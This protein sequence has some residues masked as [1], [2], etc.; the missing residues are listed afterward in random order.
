MSET[1][2]EFIK[3]KKEA[4]HELINKIDSLNAD[5]TKKIGEVF[6]S[7]EYKKLIGEYYGIEAISLYEVSGTENTDDRRQINFLY[8]RIDGQGDLPMYWANSQDNP[9]LMDVD[10]FKVSTG[11]INSRRELQQEALQNPEKRTSAELCAKYISSSNEIDYILVHFG[12]ILAYSF[13]YHLILLD[14]N[15][16]TLADAKQAWNTLIEAHRKRKP[17][18][19]EKT[20]I[21]G[22][23]D[24]Y[25]YDHN[26]SEYKRGFLKKNKIHAI[27]E[28]FNNLVYQFKEFLAD[29]KKHSKNRELV[30]EKWANKL[31]NSFLDSSQTN[32]S[33]SERI[34]H[35]WKC[36]LVNPPI[37]E[38]FCS[39]GLY[40][41]VIRSPLNPASSGRRETDSSDSNLSSAYAICTLADI[42]RFEN[43]ECRNNLNIVL[44][45][46]ANEELAR[47]DYTKT[48]KMQLNLVNKIEFL[49]NFNLF[50]TAVANRD[51]DYK[52]LI[53]QTAQSVCELELKTSGDG[54]L[55]SWKSVGVYMLFIGTNCNRVQWVSRLSDRASC[56]SDIVGDIPE[57][58]WVLSECD[59]PN[60]FARLEKDIG[61]KVQVSKAVPIG[62][63]DGSIIIF[64]N[65]D[66]K[67]IGQSNKDIWHLIR[68]GKALQ[69][70][71]EMPFRSAVHAGLVKY[72]LTLLYIIFFFWKDLPLRIFYK[73]KRASHQCNANSCLLVRKS[74]TPAR[75]KL[76][77]LFPIKDFIIATL[78]EFVQIGFILVGIA[79][80]YSALCLSYETLL[81][82][83][84]IFEK[85]M[86]LLSEY[87]LPD[88]IS[89]FLKNTNDAFCKHIKNPDLTQQE[90]AEHC[91]LNKIILVLHNIEQTVMAFSIF[92]ATT[93]IIFL[94][95]P[96]MAVGQPEWMR[97][98]AKL[99]TLEQTIVRLV[100]MVLTIDVF[101]AVLG[102]RG[103]MQHIEG[104]S[105][106]DFFQPTLIYI[107]VYICVL[108]GLAFLSKYLLGEELG[109]EHEE[110]TNEKS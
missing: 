106:L 7:P 8:E 85:I 54:V 51:I 109:K 102:A 15:K 96:G 77:S 68:F 46:L 10:K 66:D 22:I 29:P 33:L 44:R 81:T 30:I 23:S 94:L 71:L 37:E 97:R 3:D 20:L 73:I 62:K 92:L 82:L 93:G 11:D 12:E 58:G 89:S 56:I 13:L 25:E 83:S 59:K 9:K 52:S 35:F 87:L 38:E 110:K 2:N 6:K 90:I 61:L 5:Q 78:M 80:L 43:S 57:N 86:N 17:L 53:E 75:N 103:D 36:S 65:S 99:D 105:P 107:G 48:K 31:Y 64:C 32:N 45:R 76:T 42:K 95:S 88:S 70:G 69:N 14:K 74:V 50:Q 91:S 47:S 24:W 28:D 79:F 18:S 19:D 34:K 4:Y 84:P 26:K 108:V 60:L 101:S 63:S 98:F 16:I 72:L 40:V 55:V 100:A 67:S 104:R 39:H 21:T 49:E 1:P 27:Y 41:T